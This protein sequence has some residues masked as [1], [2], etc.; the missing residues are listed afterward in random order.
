VRNHFSGLFC[1]RDQNVERTATEWY[2]L[3]SFL[4]QPL[5]HTQ[6]ER[7]KGKYVLEGQVALIIHRRR[8]RSQS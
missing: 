5:G 2:R 6:A 7:T 4:E 8:P 1:E 3:I